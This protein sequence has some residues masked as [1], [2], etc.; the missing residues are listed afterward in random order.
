M[1]IIAIRMR[2]WLHTA[3]RP[4]SCTEIWEM[5]NLK[6]CWT[7]LVR[8]SRKPTA[9]AESFGDFDKDG[10]V[11]IVL[12][13]LN[14]SPALLRNEVTENKLL[15]QGVADCYNIESRGHLARRRLLL[16]SGPGWRSL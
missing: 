1:C 5:G 13:N 3:R 2:L 6:S 9:I 7:N 16:T 15:T 4:V 12:V 14:E 11:D 10:D 8:I